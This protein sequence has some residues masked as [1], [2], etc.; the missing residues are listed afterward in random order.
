MLFIV[1][2]Y[3]VDRKTVRFDINIVGKFLTFMTIV[4]FLRIAIMSYQVYA[5]GGGFD[6]SV[7]SRINFWEFTFVFW[8][9]AVF[10]MSIYYIKDV[11]KAPKW[12]WIPFVV[13]LSVLFGIGHSYQGT[14]AAVITL[15]V[16]YYVFYKYGARH[17]FGT[18]MVCHVLYD[19]I[20]YAT[21]KL[22]PYII[23]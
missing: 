2:V 18:T 14:L 12:V 8:E 7:L 21:V 23:Y 6:T 3:F 11:F 17:G 16:P 4:T 20:T 13:L 19:M 15:F 1:L 5:G 10:A 9:D 22:A